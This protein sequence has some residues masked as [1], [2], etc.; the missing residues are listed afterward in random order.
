MALV[1]WLIDR[2]NRRRLVQDGDKAPRFAKFGAYESRA[3]R[4]YREDFTFGRVE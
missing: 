3:E 4:E 2:R 1:V